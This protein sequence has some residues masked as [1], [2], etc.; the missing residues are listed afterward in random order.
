MTSFMRAPTGTSPYYDAGTLDLP[1]RDQS[2]VGAA[3]VFPPFK[4]EPR[5]SRIDWRMLHGVDINPIIRDVD[6]DTLER[7][8]AV[9]AFGDI[10]AEDTRNLT[11]LNFVKVFRLSQLTVE[12][13]LYVQDCLQTTNMWLQTDRGAMAK[14]LQAARLRVRELEAHLKMSK[15]ELRV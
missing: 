3:P 5:R 8:V 2:L 11:E 9:I 7:V 13:L 15:R 10:E 14:Y 1:M 12:Y 6:L 4:F